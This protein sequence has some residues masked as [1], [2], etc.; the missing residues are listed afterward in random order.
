MALSYIVHIILFVY[1]QNSFFGYST[2]NNAFLTHTISVTMMS[3]LILNLNSYGDKQS[4]APPTSG[5][6]AV[7][8]Q[9]T[10]QFTTDATDYSTVG[11]VARTAREFGT[12]FDLEESNDSEFN[13]N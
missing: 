5:G 10:A 11:W 6:A 2:G 4:A 13:A 1:I 7:G 3:R 9:P 12:T 8:F